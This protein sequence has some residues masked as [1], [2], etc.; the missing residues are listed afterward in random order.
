MHKFD[1]LLLCMMFTSWLVVLDPSIVCVGHQTVVKATTVASPSLLLNAVHVVSQRRGTMKYK[2]LLLY[3][4]KQY[5]TCVIKI[6][7][8]L[9]SMNTDAYADDRSI[10]KNVGFKGISN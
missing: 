10:H 4:G 7:L 2:M 3:Q 8:L 1:I 9:V 5:H 6:H